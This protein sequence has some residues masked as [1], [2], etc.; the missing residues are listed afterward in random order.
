MFKIIGDI[1]TENTK[2]ELQN[3]FTWLFLTNKPNAT[4]TN[5]KYLTHVTVM[6]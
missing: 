2:I 4:Q 5:V 3:I 6:E 1:P